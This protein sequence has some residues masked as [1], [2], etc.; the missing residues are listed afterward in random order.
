VVALREKA[1]QVVVAE[2]ARLKGRLGGLDPQVSREIARSMQRITDKL[3]HSPTVRVKELAGAPGGESYAAMLRV[4][5][6]LDPDAVRAVAQAD[7]G[8]AG[9]DAEAS[10]AAAVPGPASAEPAQGAP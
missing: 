5:F 7:A 6:D 3:L 9:L 2:L 1:A 8:L 4:L 10:G